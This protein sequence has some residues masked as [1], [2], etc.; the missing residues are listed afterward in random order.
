MAR[1]ILYVL[2]EFQELNFC[3]LPEFPGTKNF[4]RQDEK[5]LAEV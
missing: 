2:E 5:N 1:L 4:H 3:R